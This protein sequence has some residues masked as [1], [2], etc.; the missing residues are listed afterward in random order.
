[1]RKDRNLWRQVLRLWALAASVGCV[2]A[3]DL[4]T[5]ATLLLSAAEAR[6]GETVTAAVRLEMATGWHTYWFNPGESGMATEIAWELPPGVQAGAIQ[7]PPPEPYVSAGLTTYVYHDSVLLLV[8]VTLGP[9]LRPGPLELRATVSWLECEVQCVP[10][11]AA[12]S[13]SLQL[14][15]ASRPSAHAELIN[16]WRERIPKRDSGESLQLGHVWETTPS[17]STGTLTIKGSVRPDLSP[18]DFYAYPSQ[19]FELTPEVK[20][21]TS[22]PGK[23]AFAKTLKH[24]SG[25]TFP[26]RIEGILV[27]PAADGS[28]PKAIEVAFQLASTPTKATTTAMAATGNQATGGLKRSLLAML[29]LAFLGGLI[30]NIMPCVLPV[31]ALK[32]LGFV[33]QSKEEPERVKRLGLAFTGGVLASFLAMAAVVISVQQ[34]GGGASW[35][36]QM[37]N[38]Y[39]RLGLLVVVLLVALNLFGVFEITLGSTALGT[40][41]KLASKQ[42]YT[43]AFLNGVLA[44]ALGTSC[45]APMLAIAV[46]FAFTQPP[47]LVLLMFLTIGL[48]LAAPYLLL[49]WKPGWL[50]LLPKPG[51]WMQH[52]KVAMGFPMLATAVWMFEFTAPSYG[53]GGVL[54]LGMFLA[55]IALTA[56]VWG[57]F[58]QRG[59]ARRGLAMASCV[60]L[61]TAGFVVILEGQ[62]H[63]RNPVGSASPAGYVK[64]IPD[65]LEWWPWSP[66]AVE[67]ARRQGRVALVDFTAKWCP[68]CRS[69]KKFAID[70]PSVRARLQELNGMVFRADYTDRNPRITEELRRYERAGVPLVLVFPADP[71][72]PPLVL[73]ELL[74]P[75]IVLEALNQA[76]GTGASVAASGR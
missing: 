27:Q 20:P 45:T 11:S 73:P 72:R 31:I 65:G 6:P 24:F 51:A 62:L 29:G 63:W 23:F 22:D 75:T 39:F 25:A 49:S 9:N 21:V 53:P 2:A 37:Q 14:G 16:Q 52:F 48:G 66:A 5:R 46:G 76:A 35:G 8:P 64:D 10:G 55:L 69:N 19:D 32:I 28:P 3:A 26:D 12:V 38:P 67:D 60:G 71:S 7:W 36:M 44:T 43:G 4:K 50:K 61:L 33:Q 34:A 41:S 17:T 18:T 59:T 13:A 40:A 15:A 47:I 56:W 42:G 74:T 57:E 54:W 68:N 1:M 70:I 58:V 30:L